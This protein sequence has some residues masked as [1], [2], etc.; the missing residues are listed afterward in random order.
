MTG[1]GEKAFV[2]M[3]RGENFK[4][5]KTQCLMIKNPVTYFLF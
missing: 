2:L 4:L 3:A 1:G 5:V